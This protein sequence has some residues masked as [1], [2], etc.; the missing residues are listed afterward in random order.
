MNSILDWAIGQAARELGIKP[1]LASLVYKSY[2]KFIRETIA[3]FD[4]ENLSEEDFAE[5][6]TN[7]NIP[8]IGKMY[9]GYDKVE[10]YRRK[11]KYLE[12]HVKV[13]RNKTHV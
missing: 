3:S 5:T 2:W 1:A 7:F 9:T 8:Y 11:I 12:N 6:T 10:K 4:L 13:K